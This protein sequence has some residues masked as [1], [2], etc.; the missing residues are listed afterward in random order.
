MGSLTTQPLKPDGDAPM[1]RAT[2]LAVMSWLDNRSRLFYLNK[3]MSKNN[4]Q[5]SA[6]STQ[7]RTQLND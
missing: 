3:L 4:V 1:N 5:E 6:K 7:T 2:I